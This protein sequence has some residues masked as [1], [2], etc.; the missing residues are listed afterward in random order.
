MHGV[1]ASNNIL[2]CNLCFS[3]IERS[4]IEN[5]VKVAGIAV[6]NFNKKRSTWG[7]KSLSIEEVVK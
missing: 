4:N 6:I 1:N 3:L 2:N 5:G 7:W